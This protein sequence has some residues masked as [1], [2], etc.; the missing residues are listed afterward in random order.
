MAKVRAHVFIDGRVQGVFFRDSTRREAERRGLTG[1]V[2]N[3]P[4]GR[5][6]AVLEGEQE[7]VARLVEWCGHGP[8]G[9]QVRRLEV[10]WQ[11]YVGEFHSFRL[12]RF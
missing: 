2:R 10:D 6:E 1:W 9:A 3:C 8:P 11:E 5:V 7:Q 4:D 12:R